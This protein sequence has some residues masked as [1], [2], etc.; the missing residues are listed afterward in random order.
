MKNKS[1]YTTISA[2]ITREEFTLLQDYCEKKGVT[3]SSLIRDLLLREVD[4]PLPHN[5][6]GRNKIGYNKA[7]DDFSWSIEFDNGEVVEVIKNISPEFIQELNDEFRKSI[8]ERVV[9][10]KKKNKTSVPVP[11]SLLRGKK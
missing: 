7:T 11:S 1:E 5:I 4:I 10:I 9:F 3:I 8:E 6:A 2:K